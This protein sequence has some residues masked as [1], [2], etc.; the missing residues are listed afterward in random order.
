[1][2]IYLNISFNH[3]LSKDNYLD[4]QTGLSKKIKKELMVLK[5]YQIALKNHLIIN[6]KD[7][8]IIKLV[9]SL[10]IIFKILLK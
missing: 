10:I 9:G 8:F 6:R 2:D 7:P 5:E 1:M 4:N 3:L